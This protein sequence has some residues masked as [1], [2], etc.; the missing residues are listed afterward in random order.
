MKRVSILVLIVTVLGMA[1]CNS[2]SRSSGLKSDLDTM[3]YYYGYARADGVMDYLTMQAGIDTNYMK[4]FYDGF[5]DGAKNYS[6]KDMAYHEGKRIAMLIN[7]QWIENLN[8]DVFLGDSSQTVNRRAVLSGFFHGMKNKDNMVFIQSDAF[9]QTKMTKMKDEFTRMKFA[10]HIAAS[11]TFIAE[12]KNKEG[13][14]TT[15]SGLQ[16]KIITQGTGQIPEERARIKVNYRGTLVDGT[17]FDSSFK[18]NEP[19]TFR[20]NQVIQGWTEALKMMPAGS[21]WMLYIPQDLAYRSDIQPNIPPYSTLIFEVELLEI[22][23]D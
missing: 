13:V 10:D 23:P 3:S 5:K 2:F 11:E 20:V 17:E 16:Y 19:A 12:N 14:I 6:A 7:N 9:Y 4:A 15:S 18:N 22:I 21:K 1:S 8:Q